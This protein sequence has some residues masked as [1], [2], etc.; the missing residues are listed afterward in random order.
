V[1]ELIIVRVLDRTVGRPIDKGVACT[2]TMITL[3]PA[4]SPD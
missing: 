4:A 3:H 1:P 2:Q